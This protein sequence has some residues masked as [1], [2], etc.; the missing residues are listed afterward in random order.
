MSEKRPDGLDDEIEAALDGVDLQSIGKSEDE[1]DL[2]P[3]R[4]AARAPASPAPAPG[5]PAGEGLK[6]GT[7]VGISG[8]DVFVELGPRMQGVASLA[9]FDQPPLAGQSFEFKLRGR[10]EE[11]DLWLLSRRE[12]LVLASWRELEVGSIVKAQVKGQ[13]AGGLELKIGPHAAFMP[14]SQVAIG[15]VQDLSLYLSQTLVCQ[16]LEIDR[17][18]ERVVLSRRAVLERE[19][20]QARAEAV[21]TLAPGGLV[22]GKVTRV[23]KYG[24]FVQIAPGL[25]G[26]VHVSNLSRKRVEDAAEVLAVGQDVQAMVLEIKEGGKRIGLGLKQLEPDPWDDVGE[27]L[28]ED[29]VVEG[30]VVRLVE[31]GAF[32]EIEPG[33]EGLLHVSQ[34]GKSRVRRP[35]DSL[36]VGEDLAVRVLSIEPIERRISLSRLD[37]HGAVLGSEEAADPS[38]VADALSEGAAAPRGTSLGDIFRKALGKRG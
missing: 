38:A 25:E 7:V 22:R 2:A 27:R 34:I 5:A 16:V 33:L 37:A 28:H 12:A 31:F 1:P 35:Q 19:R 17:A 10:D 21:D 13:N 26:L 32:I 11:N 4:P 23:E 15:H 3:L 30:R 36:K 20:E 29:S 24:A 9:E 14:A 18:R 6:V 8:K